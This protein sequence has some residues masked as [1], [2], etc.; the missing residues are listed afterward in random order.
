MKKLLLLLV[1]CLPFPVNAQATETHHYAIEMAGI[2]VGTMTAVREQHADNRS[3]YTLISDVKVGLLVYTV[4]IYY[5]VISQFVGQKLM[6]STVNAQTNR[7]NYASRTEWKDDRY[8]ISANQYKYDRQAVERANIDFSVSSLYF[9]EPTGRKKV[10]AEYFGDYFIL[11][12][13][14]AGT[15]RALLA[16]REDEYVYE[17]GRLVKVIK[18]N[19][20]KNFV[21]RLLD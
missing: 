12:K 4:K 15:Y 2:R 3:T 1:V 17:K 5:K 16:D 11:S 9:Y 19:K 14:T 18:H 6:L 8:V 13:T 7:G 21:V 20:V 10:Y